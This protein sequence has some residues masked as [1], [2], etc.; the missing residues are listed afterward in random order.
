[1][2]VKFNSRRNRKILS[3]I[4]G[5]SVLLSVLL[6]FLSDRFQKALNP[7]VEYAS[8]KENYIYS[9]LI[10]AIIFIVSFL[11]GFIAWIVFRHKK[12]EKLFYFIVFNILGILLLFVADVALCYKFWHYN[13]YQANI[14][15][16]ESI[17]NRTGVYLDTC[18]QMVENEIKKKGLSMNDF[19]ILSYDYERALATIPK[20]TSNRFYSINIFYSINSSAEER[21][22]AASY[23]VNFKEKIKEIYDVDISD[24]KAEKQRESLRKNLGNLRDLLEK[25]P[26][27]SDKSFDELKKKLELI[28]P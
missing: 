9:L 12:P 2:D 16:N 4:I 28:R 20:D 14:D 13:K 22:R 11:L 18:M 15:Y 10:L 5:G 7:G 1:M 17:A 19:R 26:D 3:I 6:G 23:L 21:V 25:R 27:S 24:K 8:V